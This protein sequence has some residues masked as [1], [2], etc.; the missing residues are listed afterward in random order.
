MRL[1]G[2]DKTE[3]EEKLW[4]YGESQREKAELEDRFTL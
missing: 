4:N 2:A 3:E 1:G